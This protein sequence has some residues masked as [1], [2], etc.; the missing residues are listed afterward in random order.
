[1]RPIKVNLKDHEDAKSI[2][3]NTRKLMD[4][5][6][7]MKSFNIAFDASREQR[8]AIR[9]LVAEAKQKSEE[10]PNLKFRVRGPPW[11]PYLKE[12]KKSNTQS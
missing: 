2:I 1:M 11:A 10:S 12:M 8:D 3:N 5:P 4:A 6:D 7:H 9:A